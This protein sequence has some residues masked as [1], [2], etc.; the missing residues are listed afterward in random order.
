MGLQRV[1][2]DWVTFTFTC[3]GFAGGSNGKASARN[4]GDLGLIPGLGRYPG[5]DNG[6]PLQYSGLE[7]CMKYSVR[8]VSKSQTLLS[9]FTS[10]SFS[11][12]FPRSFYA[13]I[14]SKSIRK[15]LTQYMDQWS[16][17]SKHRL[18]FLLI[19]PSIHRF[20]FYQDII[21]VTSKATS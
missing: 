1:E 17:I 12:T 6:Y 16:Y 20:L 15:I 19:H 21:P 7:N 2:H 5:E 9:N 3:L 14:C 18:L 8:G 11:Y 13:S 10:L 4:V